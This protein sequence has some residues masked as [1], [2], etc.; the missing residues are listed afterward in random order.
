MKEWIRFRELRMARYHAK[1][2]EHPTSGRI[3]TAC[4]RTFD[5]LD[6]TDS[7][8]EPPTKC[9]ACV[10]RL[11]RTPYLIPKGP[12]VERLMNAGQQRKLLEVRQRVLELQSKRLRNHIAKLT[13]RSAG[14]SR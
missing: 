4:G 13:E 3:V 11:L 5:F 12:E 7:T 6:A 10:R 9:T 2:A 8:A 14:G 1:V